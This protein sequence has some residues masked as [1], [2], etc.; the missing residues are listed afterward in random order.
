MCGP[1]QLILVVLMYS[2][3]CSSAFCCKL[4]AVDQ[5]TTPFDDDYVGVYLCFFT[6][7]GSGYD[8]IGDCAGHTMN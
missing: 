1:V 2:K 5:Y 7:F 8:Q 3:G 6:K 4:N